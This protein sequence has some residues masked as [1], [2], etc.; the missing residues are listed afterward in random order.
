MLLPITQITTL[1][2]VLELPRMPP[3]G[4][5][6]QLERPEEVV[7]LL[8][9]GPNGKDLVDQVLHAHDAILAEV[10]FDKLV[11]GERDALLVDLAVATLID[12]FA[13]RLEGGVAVGN[14]GLDDLEEF[15]GGF[16]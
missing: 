1:N 12:K 2:E 7:R 11:V 6:A 13:D 9:V 8:E 3:T 10:V 4:G 15:G 14:V 5:I 16:A